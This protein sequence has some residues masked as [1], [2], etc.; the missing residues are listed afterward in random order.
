MNVGK[1]RGAIHDLLRGISDDT[2]ISCTF[3]DDDEEVDCWFNLEIITDLVNPKRVAIRF[4][5]KED[6]PER[7]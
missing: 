7:Q 5:S 6:F 2:E 4:M 1:L 3:E